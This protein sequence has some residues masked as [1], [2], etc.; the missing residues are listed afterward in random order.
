[1][2]VSHM[3]SRELN[4]QVPVLFVDTCHH[5][6][7]TLDL[8]ERSRSHYGFDL[9][10]ARAEGATDPASFARLHGERLW[11]TDP[12]SYDRIAKTDP[13][14]RALDILNVLCEITGRRRSQGDSRSSLRILSF[15]PSDGRFKLNPLANWNYDQVWAYV[16]ENSV[17]YNVLHDRG[18]KSVGD[19]HSTTPTKPGENE[20]DGRWRGQARTECG[21]HKDY[22]E[23]R[24]K[25]RREKAAAAAA[26]A[27]S[28]DAVSADAASAAPASADAVSVNAASAAAVAA[29]PASNSA[30][31]TPAASAPSVIV[32]AGGRTSPVP[33]VASG[34][35]TPT[36]DYGTP[37]N[38]R[39][40]LPDSGRL[41]Q[42]PGRISEDHARHSS[43][44]SSSSPPD[45]F[46]LG[47]K[48]RNR[49]VAF[50]AS[51]LA[52]PELAGRARAAVEC[53]VS[54][55]VVVH[56]ASATSVHPDLA[57]LAEEAPAVV[58]FLELPSLAEIISQ[59]ENA[60]LR[61]DTRWVWVQPGSLDAAQR[62]SVRAAA[63]GVGALVSIPQKDVSR[64]PA[65]G[66]NGPEPAHREESKAPTTESEKVEQAE[67]EDED[68]EVDADDAVVPWTLRV[69][70]SRARIAVTTAGLLPELSARLGSELSMWIPKD[71]GVIAERLLLRRSDASSAVASALRADAV[72]SETSAAA[73]KEQGMSAHEYALGAYL[74]DASLAIHGDLENASSCAAGM[75]SEAEE[76]EKDSRTGRITL[77]GAGP[78]DPSYLTFAA[79][80][81]VREADLVLADYLIPDT[82]LRAACPRGEVRVA[83]KPK[84]RADEGQTSLDTVA[85]AEALQGKRVVRLKS[86]DPMLFGRGG[87]EISLYRSHNIPVCTIPGVTSPVAVAARAGIPLTMR[88]YSD[89]LFIATAFGKGGKPGD[90]PA[91][92][93]SATLMVMMAASRLAPL[94][95]HLVTEK[96]YP[97][98]TPCAM[99]ERASWPTERTTRGTIKSFREGW[100]G[101]APAPPAIL[102]IGRVVEAVDLEEAKHR[103]AQA[104]VPS[105]VG[106]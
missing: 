59:P 61:R 89:T 14:H 5:F 84:G 69:H 26:D 81:A 42:G 46:L 65:S 24:L 73:R 88:D 52:D 60:V 31:P 18:Y 100:E 2:V 9:Y 74:Q 62:K 41:R 53:G 71:A 92:H 51:D 105:P 27:A 7:E 16:T 20:R 57:A 72:E 86:G 36:S 76:M 80:K 68:E 106:Q 11:E 95:D 19:V 13:A 22:F 54:V 33:S 101:E 4:L 40:N 50:V 21:L 99:V 47:I 17:P 103:A 38:P 29:P 12:E 85:V 45:V 6:A 64:P 37:Q 34:A 58:R 77:V 56:P 3:I 10:V 97:Q 93:P 70:P 79:A 87:E 28:A 94:L 63:R 67:D 75:V 91:Y 55:A 44:S 25:A 90:P 8:A 1:M 78:G 43:A 35:S 102:V 96:G 104:S 30:A 98:D 82:V 83:S 15:D 23:N 66:E 49:S 39:A 48:L 32:P